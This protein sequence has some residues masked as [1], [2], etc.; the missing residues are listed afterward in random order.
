MVRLKLHVFRVMA[1]TVPSSG[2]MV[3]IVRCILI[4]PVTYSNVYLPNF[5]K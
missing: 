5:D 1:V 2:Q 3:D 4:V